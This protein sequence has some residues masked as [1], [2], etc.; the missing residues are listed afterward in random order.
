MCLLFGLGWL[1]I[2][3]WSNECVGPKTYS[4]NIY[5]LLRNT[6]KTQAILCQVHKE[7]TKISQSAEIMELALNTLSDN[8]VNKYF[9]TFDQIKYLFSP[10]V[11]RLKFSD[12][13]TFLQY[14]G[15]VL[16]LCL[17]TFLKFCLQSKIQDIWFTFFSWV[18]SG[19]TRV[20][21]V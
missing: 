12:D 6:A 3:E 15:A 10:F 19:L 13:I 11:R 8:Y 18:D 16:W 2:I 14:F 4:W 21:T 20:V 17:A 1:N 7:A 9:K 5:W